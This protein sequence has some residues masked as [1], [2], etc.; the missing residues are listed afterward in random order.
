MSVE[1]EGVDFFFTKGFSEILYIQY[2]NKL[3]L[4]RLLNLLAKW[5]CAL[6]CVITHAPIFHYKGFDALYNL[7][8]LDVYARTNFVSILYI[9]F[10]YVKTL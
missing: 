4:K 2:N 9:F 3:S 1:R 6:K 10:S 7:Y 5:I 8:F